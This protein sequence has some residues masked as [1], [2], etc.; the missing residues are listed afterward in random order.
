MERKSTYQAMPQWTSSKIVIQS[1]EQTYNFEKDSYREEILSQCI[2][3][4][5]FDIIINEAS[6]L[7]GHCWTKKRINDQIKLP[8]PVI[9]LAAIAVVLTILYMIL[10]YLS[11]SSANGQVLL[12]ISIFSVSIGGLIAFGLSIYNFCRE[13]SKFKSLDEIIKEDLDKYFYDVNKKYE[14]LLQFI[15][16]PESRWIECNILKINEKWAKEENKYNNIERVEEEPEKE[17]EQEDE[18]ILS[19]KH[20]KH[21]SLVGN[22]K[23]LFKT[24]SRAVSQHLKKRSQDFLETEMNILFKK[25]N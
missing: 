11:A 1:K 12:A 13:I 9:I 19:K 5:N 25:E 22:A 17:N 18:K 10:L 15:Y 8:K 6:K 23:D 4:N 20:S 3:K 16:I 24:H 21:P 2:N 7:L 14:G